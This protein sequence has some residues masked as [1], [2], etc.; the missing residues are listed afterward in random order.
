M[1]RHILVLVLVLLWV[2]NPGG[3]QRNATA[4]VIVHVSPEAYVSARQVLLRF[5]V[6]GDGSSESSADPIKIIAIARAFTGQHIRLVA[7]LV[8]L[9]GPAGSVAAA[10]RWSGVKSSAS[11]GGQRA[12]CSSGVLTVGDPKGIIA[13]WQTS[14]SLTCTVT[15]KLANTQELAP[16][17]YSGVV[18]LGIE[19][20]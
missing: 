15:F 11:A 6:T 17:V 18:D 5:H 20:Q 12:T 3:A 2:G 19:M 16:G 13:S 4:T 10:I 1:S 8:G 9:N 14:G 7:S